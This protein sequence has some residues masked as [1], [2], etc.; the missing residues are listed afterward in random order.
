MPG[1]NI[2]D[3]SVTA[4]NNGNSDSSIN[5][6]EGQARASVN[7]SARSMMAAHAK[8]R[9]LQNGSIV[10]GGTA[11]AQVFTS[12][13][14]YI[15]P[16]PTGLRVLLKI[17]AGLTNTGAV[18]LNMDGIGAFPVF[19]QISVPA[20]AGMLTENSYCEFLYHDNLWVFLSSVTAPTPA[21]FDNDASIATTAFVR[22]AIIGNAM[23]VRRYLANDTYPVTTSTTKVLV[24]CKGAGGGGGGATTGGPRGGSGGEGAESWLF[25]FA[26]QL[27]GQVITI[28]NG[29][30]PGI[31]GGPG[32]T[33]SLGALCTALGGQ[34]GTRGDFG[35]AGGVGGVGGTNTWGM[36]GAPGQPGSD[37]NG[38]LAFYAP[39]G[40]KGGGQAGQSGVANS[41]GGGG[42]GSNSAAAGNGGSGIVVCFEYG[43]L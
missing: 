27:S 26:N 25:A 32:G 38:A 15:A 31:D 37:I 8:T 10:T 9:N 1:E 35:G 3:W 28:G 24:Y 6:L 36:P 39:G 19:T 23:N 34:G 40:G 16:I 29:G 5:W 17:G 4:I 18:T 7:N 11:N 21:A 42:N 2:Q 43:P 33:T 20:T 13:V 12:G 41:G 14:G 30:I 22:D